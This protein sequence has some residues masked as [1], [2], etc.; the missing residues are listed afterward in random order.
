MGE[1]IYEVRSRFY[2]FSC[3]A[4]YQ[5]DY[6]TIST[7][8]VNLTAIGAKDYNTAVKAAQ[9]LVQKGVTA[10]ELCGGFGIQGVAQIQAAVD[11]K[12]AIGVVRFDNHPGLN[13]QSGD[14]L[15]N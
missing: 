3:R 7:P 1:R 13:F 8:E 12:I 15:F 10:I 2:L 11:P 5:K 6:Q 14:Q 4:D 9:F